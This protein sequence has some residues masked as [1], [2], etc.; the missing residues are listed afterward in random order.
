MIFFDNSPKKRFF[1]ENILLCL[2]RTGDPRFKRFSFFKSYPNKTTLPFALYK[3]E[4][5]NKETFH[6][7]GN[8]FCPVKLELPVCT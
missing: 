3:I 7:E 2:R 6:D 5:S 4:S 1:Q 8:I